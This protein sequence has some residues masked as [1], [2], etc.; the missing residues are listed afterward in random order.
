MDILLDGG[1]QGDP[2]KDYI[3]DYIANSDVTFT[4]QYDTYTA[5]RSNSTL[6]ISYRFL[7]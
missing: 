7:L 1:F 3:E 4:A 2:D 5:Y 6:F